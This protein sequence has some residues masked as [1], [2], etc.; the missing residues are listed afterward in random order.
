MVTIETVLCD[1]CAAIIPQRTH[2]SMF[3]SAE[4][5]APVLRKKLTAVFL[6]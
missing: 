4:L 1:I 2:Q 5:I 6:N 3:S